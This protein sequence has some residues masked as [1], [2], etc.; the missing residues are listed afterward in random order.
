MKVR[1]IN[2]T[3]SH[4][5]HCGSWLAHW[6]KFSKKKAGCCS[7]MFCQNQAEVGAH[8]QKEGI[9]NQAWY[10]IPLCKHH[11]NQRGQSIDLYNPI[12]IPANVSE[13]CGK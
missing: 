10:I 2:G 9:L 4:Q 1:N 8:V 7:E 13:T 6:E 12:L 5:C 11:N 3:S